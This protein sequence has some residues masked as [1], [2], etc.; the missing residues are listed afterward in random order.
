MWRLERDRERDAWM[1]AHLL[2]PWS[3]QPL[4]PREFLPGGGTV[5]EDQKAAFVDERLKQWEAQ[6]ADPR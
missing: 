6:R 4:N 1:L 2:S 3:D 5:P